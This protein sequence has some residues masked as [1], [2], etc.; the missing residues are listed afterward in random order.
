M[1]REVKVKTR[2]NDGLIALEVSS[3]TT[4]V[5]ELTSSAIRSSFSLV[6]RVRFSKLGHF[7]I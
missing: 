5:T 3:V 6:N 1:D 2:E 4:T 7:I